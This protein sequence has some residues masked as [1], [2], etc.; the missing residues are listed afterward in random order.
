MSILPKE[1]KENLQ[2]SLE[3]VIRKE[4]LAKE[5]QKNLNE[6]NRQVKMKADSDVRLKKLKEEYQ[7]YSS[8]EKPDP[9]YKEKQESEKETV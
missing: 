7:K 6:Y 3:D 4:T 8:V 1:S 9:A 5:Y 2:K